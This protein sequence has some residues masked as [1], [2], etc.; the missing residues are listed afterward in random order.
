MP[1]K[2]PPARKPKAP[3]KSIE[4]WQRGTTKVQLRLS[5]ED[6]ALIDLLRE[7]HAPHAALTASAL[8]GL[9]LRQEYERLRDLDLAPV[10]EQ[11]AVRRG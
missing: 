4:E 9:L 5:P 3:G 6:A 1:A 10:R 7:D 8:V 11:I 2:S